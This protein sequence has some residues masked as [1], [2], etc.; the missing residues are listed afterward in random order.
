MFQSGASPERSYSFL[1]HACRVPVQAR[2]FRRSAL[3]TVRMRTLV[4]VVTSGSTR[5]VA[6][7]E[8]CYITKLM[9][10]VT[11]DFVAHSHSDKST[12]HDFSSSNRQTPDPSYLLCC[13]S[14]PSLALELAEVCIPWSCW[15]G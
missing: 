9:I 5:K 8:I 11:A 3:F 13:S 10:D 4:E 6:L 15:G 2:I 12:N 1:S 14:A 7:V